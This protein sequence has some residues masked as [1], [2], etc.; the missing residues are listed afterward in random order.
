MDLSGKARFSRRDILKSSGMVAAAA[1][2]PLAAS[3]Q[4]ETAH[5]EGGKMTLVSRGTQADNLYT[6]I[7]VRP[8]I[9]A[10]GTYTIITGSTSLPEVKQAM[11]EASQYYVHLDELMPAVGGEIAKLM[12]APGAIV[13]CGCEAAIAL[14]TVACMCGTDPE[15]SQAFPYYK[16]KSEVIIPKYARNPY[17]FG[18]RMSGPKIVEVETEEDL[19]RSITA[20]TAMIYVMSGPRAFEEPLSIKTICSIAKEFGVPVFVDAAA[21]EPIVP[22]IHIAA[23]A[24]FVGYSG[25]KCMRGPQTAGVL[26][27]P[28]DL[29]HAAFWNAAPHHNWGR[30]LKVGK[31]EAMGMLAAVRQWYKRDHEAEQKQWLAWDNSIADALKGIPSLTTKI[32]MPTD[33]LS[34]RAPTLSIHWDAAQVGITGEELVKKLDEGTPRILVIGGSGQRPDK[35]ESSIG[36]MPYMMHPEDHAI[37]AEVLVKY[38]KNPG[39][40][41]NPPVDH[42]ET[43]SLAGSWHVVIQYGVGE[44]HQM[45]TLSQQGTT[46]SGDQKGELYST[47]LKGSVEGAHA[48][49]H[50]TMTTSGQEFPWIF[51]GVVRGG[52]FSGDVDMG[53]Y[54][55][56]T[57]TATRA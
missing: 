6:Q 19:R 39:H 32:N 26:L 18:V 22:N 56:A 7:G 13:T 34:N 2:L 49:L 36:I 44:G 31:E 54:G 14:A 38:L 55:P 46:V 9:N 47:S 43:A 1:A 41:E 37:I 48:T 40:Y 33:D 35:M 57:F 12:G 30:A 10:R 27:G 24:T 4:S 15:K 45:W 20:Q 16:A 52:T 25:G 51:T 50:S 28:K 23:G 17:D 53:E 42:S 3:A 29:T 11:F 5:G 8:L 21:E